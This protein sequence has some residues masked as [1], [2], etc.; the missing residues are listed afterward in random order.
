MAGEYPPKV[1]TTGVETPPASHAVPL[2]LLEGETVLREIR[3]EPRRVARYINLG[4]SLLGFVSF[5]LWAPVMLVAPLADKGFIDD[6]GTGALV[7]LGGLAACQ[8]LFWLV[9][10]PAVVLASKNY[11]YWVTDRRI[12]TRSGMIGYKIS[13]I[14]LERVSDVTVHRNVFAMIAKAPVLGIRDMASNA[15]WRGP[16]WIGV[17]EA[18]AVQHDILEAVAKANQK[19]GRL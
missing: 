11:A 2:P 5:S 7:Y 4:V 14:P 17:T 10:T 13:S 9:A 1:V 3:P 12:V 18:E 8:L 6:F 19:N 15:Q 16:R